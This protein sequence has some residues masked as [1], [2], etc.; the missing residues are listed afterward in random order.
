MQKLFANIHLVL[1][2]GD[3]VQNPPKYVELTSLW[4]KG[5]RY[6]CQF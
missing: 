4:R 1:L 2:F 3:S 5:R 6:W